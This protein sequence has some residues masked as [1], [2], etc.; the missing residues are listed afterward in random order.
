MTSPFD[1]L[2]SVTDV[3]Q[4]LYKKNRGFNKYVNYQMGSSQCDHHDDGF[5]SG[6]GL[7]NLSYGYFEDK[8]AVCRD[9]EIKT[10][11]L[12]VP[13]RW[14][15]CFK[16]LKH[17]MLQKEDQGITFYKWDAS[18]QDS[19][20]CY[21][22]VEFESMPNYVKSVF[23]KTLKRIRTER[24]AV[25]FLKKKAHFNCMD[26]DVVKERIVEVHAEWQG[27]LSGGSDAF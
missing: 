23:L 25:K 4:A 27:M 5:W 9:G 16:P 3:L 22:K 1:L 19:M 17:Y 12:R 21:R 6:I 14:H 10:A 26:L 11:K 13:I 15:M 8:E 24:G 20:A 18:D 2:K 7:C